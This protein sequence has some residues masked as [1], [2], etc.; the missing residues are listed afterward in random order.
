[1]VNPGVDKEVVLAVQLDQVWPFNF[2][3]R[4]NS[5]NKRLV[6]DLLAI[7]VSSHLRILRVA[8]IQLEQTDSTVAYSYSIAHISAVEQLE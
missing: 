7:L 3:T 6:K 1:M 8:H 2:V 5:L 4:Q